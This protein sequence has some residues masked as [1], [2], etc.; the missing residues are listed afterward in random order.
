M[1]TPTDGESGIL[2]DLALSSD[3][4]PATEEDARAARAAREAA[5]DEAV[6]TRVV[7]EGRDG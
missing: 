6:A 2:R 3:P 7:W 1:N 4:A 5:V